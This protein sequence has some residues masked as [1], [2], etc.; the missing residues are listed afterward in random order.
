MRNILIAFIAI[1][2]AGIIY[3]CANTSTLTEMARIQ[4]QHSAQIEKITIVLEELLEQEK[5]TGDTT[6][7]NSQD[8]MFE[9]ALFL[10]KHGRGNVNNQ[11]I[12]ILGYLGGGKAENALLEMLGN[13]SYNRNSS[14]IINALVSMR[15]NKLRPVIIKLLKSGNTQDINAAMNAINNRSLNILKKPD[16]PLVIEVLNN[17]SGNRNNRYNR[18]NLL[19]IV[20]RMDQDTGVK[21]ICE[22]LETVDVNQQR[23]LIYIPMNAQI[24]LS[25]KS[26]LKIIKA[27]DEP[28]S[29]N[30]S[31]FQALCDAIS[32]KGDL[33]LMD[34][35]LEWADFAIENNSL[36]S[37]YINM[38]NR[39][40]DP[41]SA[42]IFLDLCLLNKKSRNNY[43]RN[44]LKNFP[45]IIQ[46]DGKYQ[47]VDD[48]TMK[49]LLK[50]RAKT[51]ARLNARD[52]RRASKKKK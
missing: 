33:R 16:L 40:R 42:E 26:W 13:G 23:E 39:M 46:N 43:H 48:K 18:N 17:M 7:I 37:S 21:Y 45:G 15:S 47:L 44:Y 12:A 1:P 35:A 6:E 27:L 20:C 24:N 10:A 8:E 50:K 2:L 11:A 38:L 31:A 28:N 19:K 5:Q 34:Y 9:A 51:I 32:R 29:Q 25:T 4:E 49:K 52:E 22:V 14:Y 3:G 36:R 41:K 30:I